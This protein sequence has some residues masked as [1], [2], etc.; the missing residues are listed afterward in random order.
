MSAKIATALLGVLVIGA[1]IG[2]LAH[3]SSPI[4]TLPPAWSYQTEGGEGGSAQVLV[5]DE[6]GTTRCTGWGSNTAYRFN[7]VDNHR[8]ADILIQK[9]CL[10]AADQKL[11]DEKTAL[12]WFIPVDEGYI[13]VLPKTENRNQRL[14]YVFAKERGLYTTTPLGSTTYDLKELWEL[15][16]HESFVNVSYDWWSILTKSCPDMGVGDEFDPTTC[17]YSM[18]DRQGK[19]LAKD[20]YTEK[21]LTAFRAS[22][23]D[24]V[25]NG[26]LFV[27]RRAQPGEKRSFDY[28]FLSLLDPTLQTTDLGTYTDKE[29]PPG[30]GCG[31]GISSDEHSISVTGCIH[32][33]GYPDPLV[34]PLVR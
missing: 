30:K 10:L 17:S 12:Y 5:Q 22:W 26:F 16:P 18:Y 27:L 20:F 15:P 23:F 6:Q 31:I 33:I 34:L 2:W 28:V 14:V 8:F 24:E 19:L 3:S 21:G 4:G 7:E 11:S 9:K 25:H 1:A 13:A 29:E 32:P